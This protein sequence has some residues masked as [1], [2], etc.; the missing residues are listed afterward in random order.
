MAYGVEART[1]GATTR[2]GYVTAHSR[3][4]MPP[5]DPPTTSGPGVDPE[6]VG[7][8]GLG[9]DLVADGHEREPRAPRRAVR[10]RRRRARSCPGSRPARWRPRRTSGRCRAARPGPISA[11]PPARRSGGPGRPGRHVAVAGQGV[12][13]EDRVVAR[14]VQRAPGLVGQ[15][16]RPGSRPPV[17]RSSGPTAANCRRPAVVPRPPA[18]VAATRS[19]LGHQA[20]LAARKPASRSA[21]MSSMCSMP[22]GQPDQARGDAGGQLLAPRR[23]L[24]V[25]GR[26][27]VDDQAA[28]VTD[29]GHVAVQLERLDEPLA[30]LD[31]ALDLEREHRAGAV[32]AA[33]FWPRACHG[34]D[35][36]PA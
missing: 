30:G 15:A 1:I 29:V 13:H 26:R 10:G 11:V 4:R 18:P 28:H 19:T 27:R 35:A 12:Q 17:S 36:S 20:P 9:R 6:R 5:I 25:G 24:A 22:D 23:Q 32:A 21:R 2:S 8:R 31:A 33:Y 34:L 14:R 16:G 3:A 7:E